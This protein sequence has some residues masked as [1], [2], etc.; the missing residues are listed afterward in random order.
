MKNIL[1]VGSSN[2]DLIIRVPD[3]PRPGET[4]LG[5]GF[6]SA[7]GGKGAN[8]A[9][10]AA[11]AGGRVCFIASVGDDDFGR[12]A[13][14][15]YRVDGIDTSFI[16][17]ATD[18]ASGI[19]LINVSASGEN[20]IS[21]ASGAN[22]DLLPLDLQQSKEAFR[23]ADIMLIQL[24]IPYE[25]VQE[26][27][28]MAFMHKL[29]VILNPAPAGDLPLEVMQNVNILTPNET[30][31][32]RLCGIPVGSEAD[33]GK[34]CE[35]LHSKGV[36]KVILTMGEK[37]AFVSDPGSG[38]TELIPGFKVAATDT[39]AAGDVFNGALAVAITEGMELRTSIRFAHAA[40][41]LS[42]KKAGAQPS[43]PTRIEIENF[44]KNNT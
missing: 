30:E 40:A 18:S 17:V 32:E 10:A 12:N 41:A 20:A 15:G 26:A 11:R 6:L 37:G 3:I 21:V 19:A 42:V 38:I 39:T 33:A 29:D 5:N 44:L 1:V 31:A 9:V 13:V 2:T 28:R 22:H 43:I 4:I 7:P 34:A 35:S 14:E 25:T 8:Q 16:K 23:Q 24:E 36:K 27:V